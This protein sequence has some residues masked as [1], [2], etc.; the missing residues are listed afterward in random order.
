MRSFQRTS[1]SGPTTSR[2]RAWSRLAFTC[3]SATSTVR[4][5]LEPVR[6]LFGAGPRAPDDEAV[7][8]FQ[9]SH[10]G[11]AGNAGPAPRCRDHQ[12][13]H[14]FAPARQSPVEGPV[15]PHAD[16][17]SDPSPAAFAVVHRPPPACS[18]HVENRLASAQRQAR[19]L[20]RPISGPTEPAPQAEGPRVQPGQARQ[21]VLRQRF[22]VDVRTGRSNSIPATATLC[23][24]LE[25]LRSIRPARPTVVTTSCASASV[26]SGHGP[27]GRRASRRSA[28]SACTFTSGGWAEVRCD[29]GRTSSKIEVSGA[30]GPAGVRP[31]VRG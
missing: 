1:R 21:S 18:G 4:K 25:W 22:G 28:A 13:V 5:V 30:P 14:V 31:R 8:G 27:S 19:S 10:A 3:K 23:R 12:D 6:V 9:V 26:A 20:R 7:G 24:P 15:H 17:V 2:G 16:T 29:R 11:R